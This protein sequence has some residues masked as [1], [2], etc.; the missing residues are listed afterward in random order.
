MKKT[1]KGK[2][3]LSSKNMSLLI[4]VVIIVIMIVLLRN[5]IIFDSIESK[6]INVS[7]FMTDVFHRPEEISE[8]VYRISKAKGIR[9]DVVIFGFDEKS[10]IEL[11]RYP[12]PRRVYAKFLDNVNSDPESRPSG[13]LSD[14]LF[15]EYSESSTDD[16]MLVDALARHG[17]NTVVDLFADTSSQIPD[18]GPEIEKRLRMIESLGIKAEDDV[19]QVVNVVTP[20]IREIIESG[21]IIGPATALY[22]TNPRIA[23]K[24]GADKTARRFAL[25]VKIGEKYYPSTVLRMAMLHYGVPASSLEIEMGRHVILKNAKVPETGETRDI[26]VPIDSQGTMLINFH[27][28]PGTFQVRSQQ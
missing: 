20:P 22:G 1:G 28:R 8:G 3:W 9:N 19:M 23:S 5:T 16:M 7:F 15:T 27:G 11:G 6:S 4:G 26:V 14:V 10:L 13:V 2:K 25:V 12:W 17:D 21:V 18:T 24:E